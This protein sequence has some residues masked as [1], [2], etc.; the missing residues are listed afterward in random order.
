MLREIINGYADFLYY[1][2]GARAVHSEGVLP[3]ENIVDFGL[4]DLQDNR[5]PLSEHEV[6]FKIFIDS[7]KAATS[8]HFPTDLLDAL[9]IPDTLRLHHIALED[10]FVLKYNKI[11]EKTK[12]ALDI[13]DPERLVL[14]MHELLTFE[15]DLHR[16]FTAAINSELP[17]K[18]RQTRISRLTNLIHALANLI[19]LPYGAL[20]GMKDVV[21]SG[22][23]VMKRDALASDLQSRIDGGL[24]AL[25]RYAGEAFGGERPV[26]LRFVDELKS[27]YVKHLSDAGS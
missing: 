14:L 26:L 16:Q 7:V 15:R 20:V 2:S 22:L 9:T 13:S 27:E 10:T 1:L 5:C 11:Q 3:Q 8:T 21:V 18:L 19:I 12:E 24:D 17:V 23:R 25:K 4:S 6:F